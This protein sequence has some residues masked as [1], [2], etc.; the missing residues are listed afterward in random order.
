MHMPHSFISSLWEAVK[1]TDS[2][3]GFTLI[4][5]TLIA[6]G[7]ALSFQTLSAQNDKLSNRI[8]QVQADTIHRS[9]WV[10]IEKRLESI[11][12]DVREIRNAQSQRQ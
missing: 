12:L 5:L 6:A 8:E 4:M 7:L 10:Q 3:R 1:D 9:E 11:A 2:F